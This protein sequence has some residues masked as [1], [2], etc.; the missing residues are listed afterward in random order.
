MKDSK[1]ILIIVIAVSVVGFAAY[2]HST[3]PQSNFSSFTTQSL[4]PIFK[5][6]TAS[7]PKVDWS[8][9]STIST[10]TAYGYL[11]GRQITGQKL[12]ND[13]QTEQFE[14]VTDLANLGFEKDVNLQ[15]GGP[16]S[17]SWGYKKTKN[18]KTQ[19]ILFSYVTEPSSSNPGEP[20]Q[21]VCPCKIDLTVFVSD[22]FVNNT[23][24]SSINNN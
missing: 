7:T 4:D 13:A 6:V 14:N 9:T 1:I 12:S 15:A 20:I 3:R 16:G 23:K 19:V 17:S 11:T 22:L 21:F 10:Q 18:G 5:S 2:L 8:D 24:G